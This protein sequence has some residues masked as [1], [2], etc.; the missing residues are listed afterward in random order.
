L[1]KI[2]V[3]DLDGTLLNTL[4]ALQRSV[5]LALEKFGYPEIDIPHIKKFV[6]TGGYNL[7]RKTLLYFG[8]SELKN[9]DEAY[10]IY[11]EKFRENCNYMVKPYEGM[12]E[13][14]QQLK[15]DGILTTVLSNKQQE[16]V[17]DNI[18]ST[19]GKNVFDRVYGERKGIPL[20]PDPSSLLSLLEEFGVKPEE[21][22]YFGDTATDMETGTGAGAVTVGVLWGF[23]EREELEKFH[24]YAII[25]E[26]SEIPSLVR[27]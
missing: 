22:M 13:V 5:G 14:L 26:P 12:P 15:K 4:F 17:E 2:C 24:P 18:F 20:K 10:R 11:G 8:D 27:P 19:Y 1:I 7:I 23:R 9:L 21:C 3:F 16:R 25:D 6:G